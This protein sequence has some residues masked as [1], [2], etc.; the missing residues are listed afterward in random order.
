ME[1]GDEQVTWLDRQSTSWRFAGTL[2]A[3]L[4]V[5]GLAV[6]WLVVRAN[7][8][9]R[10]ELLRQAEGVA[11]VLNVA[12]VQALRADA[13]DLI[14]PEYQQLTEQLRVA[15]TANPHWRWLYLMGR[16]PGGAIFFYADSEPCDSADHAPPGMAYSEAATELQGPFDTATAVTAGPYVDRW[17]RWISALVPV[18]DPGSGTV[19]AVLGIDV[20]ASAWRWDVAV[21]VTGPAAVLFVL[22][23]GAALV[24]AG[25]PRSR[26]SS[27]PVLW[28]LLPPLTLML[29][30]LVLGAGAL[31]WHQYR[32]S[33]DG[34]IGTEMAEYSGLLHQ[35][36]EQKGGDLA[37]TAA[38]IAA[39]AAVQEALRAGDSGRLQAALNPVF[40]ALQ[41]QHQITHFTFLDKDRVC[42]LRLHQPERCGDRVDGFTIGAA[43]RSGVAASGLEVD[44]QAALVLQTVTPVVRGAERVGYIALGEDLGSVMRRLRP[45][46]GVHW[47]A[48]LD[49]GS[50]DRPSWEREMRQRGLMPNWDGLPRCV[51]A[52]ASQGRLPDAFAAW[53]ESL[54]DT[55]SCGLG[56]RQFSVGGRYW[57]GAATTLTDA[58]GA[59]VG[60][61]LVLRDLSAERSAFMHL[62]T[63]GAML[64]GALLVLLVGFVFVLLRRTDA[65]LIGQQQE[66][67]AA[68]ARFAEL[69]EQSRTVVWEVDAQGLITYASP[70][71]LA[72]WGYLPEELVGRLHFYDLHPEAER[73]PFKRAALAVFA[74]RGAFVNLENAVQMKDGQTAWVTTNG[75][76]LL[77]ADGTLQG[78]RGSDVDVTAR[79]QAEATLQEAN[80]RLAE[81][82]VRAEELAEHAAQA[83]AAKGEFLA[84]MSHEIR[85]PLNGVI[86]M[87]ELLIDTA[88]DAEQRHYAE[89]VRS[90]GEALLGLVN[91]ILDFSKIEAGR[92]DLETLDFD[93]SSLLDDLAGTLA[94]RAQGKGLELLCGADPTVPTRLR[95]DPGRL[96]QILSNLVGNAIKF[97]AAGEVVIR[98]AMVEAVGSDVLLR[99]SVCDTGIGIPAAKRG[100]LFGKFSQVDASITRRYGGS[101]LGLAI[102]KQLAELMGGQIG[103]ESIEGQGSEF[104]FTVRLSR[105][106]GEAQN[107]RYPAADL[108]GVH[109]LVV[110]DN[111]TGR[112]LLTIR[113][114][115]WGL[116]PLAVPDGP[117]ALAA[118]AQA[119]A[120]HDPFRLA[121][122]DMQMPGMDGEAL[123]RII[124]A[125][126]RL[127]DTRMVLLTSLGLRGD[128]RR[129]QEIGFAAY[130]TKPI[131]H[132]EL[133][134]LLALALQERGAAT[135]APIVTRH[136]VRE[137]RASFAGRP[138]R[139]LLAEDN[140]VNQRVALGMLKKMGLSADAVANGVAA[141]R[142]LEALPY[143]LVLMDVQMPELDGIGATHHLRQSTAAVGNSRI[144]VIA[145]T[146]NAMQG[147][148]ER[149]LAAGMNDHVA[150]PI[151]AQTLAAALDRWLPPAPAAGDPAPTAESQSTVP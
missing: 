5:G 25:G 13:S 90:S 46:A 123:G 3:L 72:V 141:L 4:L 58:S 26:S 39:D 16:R 87:T 110:D 127:A 10:G 64:G 22:L 67:G 1:P 8:G 31:L 138:A 144:P 147:D 115:A 86:G 131:R 121:L 9:L 146:A 134:S 52:Y 128:V 71:A 133:L 132:E 105:Q 94:V 35:A 44:A 19:V 49:K 84:N 75:I 150:K 149:F 140:L 30:V 78:Y 7:R 15:C 82:G 113:L 65:S 55:P 77:A 28:R 122:I 36:L 51:V 93:L 32:R 112:D 109:A 91:D 76:P 136:T 106:A 83:S 63:R 95:G 81:A 148:R 33:V 14:K 120:Q 17:G 24:L 54:V 142:A 116:R 126:T 88:L 53:A 61:L 98:A 107:E 104:W 100:L 118:L 143:D 21:R 20:D 92:L 130:A 85:T 102:S 145:L 60:N 29:L 79:K 43:D 41:Q 129:L 119:L 34:K 73:E 108:R 111:A 23:T 27:A 96:R 139:I 66:L 125:D 18:T 45:H 80:R 6:G 74:R 38:P 101:G 12:Q 114:A 62:W 42:V 50:L 40:A 137:T 59:A 69:A 99:F 56:H 97:T 135:P 124:Q 2:A 37:A 68:A 151:L 47:A 48:V 117:S 11:R 89:T 57:W 103:V 70:V